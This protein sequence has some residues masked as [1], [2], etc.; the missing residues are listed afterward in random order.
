MF[1][2]VDDRRAAISVAS[3]CIAGLSFVVFQQDHISKWQ[4]PTFVHPD[5][6]CSCAWR[7]TSKS[8]LDGP[9]EMSNSYC[10]PGRVGGTP[11]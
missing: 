11:D 4:I 8:F 3:L 7:L 10:L 1:A 2:R 5:S 6:P 9:P